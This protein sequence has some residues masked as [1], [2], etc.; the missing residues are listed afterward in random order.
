MQTVVAQ[1]AAGERRY[2]AQAYRLFRGTHLRSN[3]LLP[4]A[5]SF[6]AVFKTSQFALH[7]SQF[8]LRDGIAR[9]LAHTPT[10]NAL[11][12]TRHRAACFDLQHHTCVASHTSKNQYNDA[13]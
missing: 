11:A 5:N 8:A 10:S 4:A 13:I 1:M 7:L 3:L 9:T 12:A 6:E 2:A